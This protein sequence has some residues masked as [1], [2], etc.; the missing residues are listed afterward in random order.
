MLTEVE[1][2]MIKRRLNT[3]GT[4]ETD[5]EENQ[6]VEDSFPDSHELTARAKLIISINEASEGRI[7][8][9]NELKEIY[10]L[11]ENAEGIIFEKVDFKRL[12]AAVRRVN[13]PLLRFFEASDITETN[14]LIVASFFW[15]SREL[16]LKK[17]KRDDKTKSEP[18]WKF[19]IADSIKEGNRNINLLTRH[20]NGEV[21]SKRKA[22]KLYEKVGI[23]QKGLGTVLE[24]L[25][26]RV[27][28]KVAKIE[29]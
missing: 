23:R 28:A 15:V 18:Q 20:K 13:N 16:G 27:L 8:V 21:I 5:Q 4:Q 14:N 1:L 10:D 17:A 12:N 22:E 9:V 25:K 29:R 7:T 2:E 3:T 26:Q 6:G 24:E 19:R 11:G